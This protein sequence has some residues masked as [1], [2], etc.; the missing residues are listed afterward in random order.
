LVLLLLLFQQPGTPLKGVTDGGLDLCRTL[1]A[2]GFGAGGSNVQ[3][4]H[5][6]PD[7]DAALTCLKALWTA[8]L[9]PT[10]RIPSQPS[11]AC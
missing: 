4:C 1:E 8:R 5:G 9:L 6:I 10:T 11:T 2:L 7:R 3:D